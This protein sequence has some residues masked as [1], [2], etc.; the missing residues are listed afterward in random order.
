M[1]GES[2]H[3]AIRGRSL[4]RNLNLYDMEDI[5]QVKTPQEIINDGE[6][7]KL[8]LASQLKENDYKLIKCVEAL[9]K[10][11][12]EVNYPYDVLALIAERDSI[13]EEYNSIQLQLAEMEV[14]NEE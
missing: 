9:V 14:S 8:K 6:T 2:Q 1:H 13:R 12:P 11:H 5:E 10:A 3:R 7:K 4:E